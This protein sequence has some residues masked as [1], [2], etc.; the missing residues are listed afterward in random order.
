MAR[1]RLRAC[2]ITPEYPPMFWGGL[3]QAVERVAGFISETGWEIHIAN[4]FTEQDSPGLL[5]EIIEST[6]ENGMMVHRVPIGREEGLRHDNIWDSPNSLAIRLMYN[7]LERLHWQHHFDV[8][9]AFFIYPLGY[10]AALLAGAYRKKLILSI[11]GNDINQYIFSPDK[12]AVLQTA[13]R[14]ADLVTSVAQD[15]L[16]KAEGLTP[17]MEKSRVIFNSITSPDDLSPTA[18]IP[19]LEGSVIGAVGLFKHSKGLPYLLKAFQAI[20]EERESSLLLVGDIREAEREIH[21]R[22]LSRFGFQD[23]HVTGP[24]PHESID[25]HL[26]RMD[27]VVIPSLS[28]GCP[29]VLLEAMMAARP[30]VATKTGAI[31]EIIQDGESGILV[32]AGDASQIKQA[33]FY[34]LDHPDEAES[35]GKRAL[36]RIAAFSTDREKREWREIYQIVTEPILPTENTEKREDV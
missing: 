30:I 7:C 27:V 13:L 10:V 19:D 2:M 28:E 35:M 33:V 6:S 5:D 32:D 24:I 15:L 12:V 16:V 4:L 11:R 23:V 22:H 9:H 36:R 1:E 18:K 25:A 31:P 29:N 21:D 8:L 20:R 3:A 14:E 34:M 26:R 17:V